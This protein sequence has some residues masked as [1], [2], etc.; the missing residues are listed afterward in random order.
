MQKLRRSRNED[1][2]LTG[3]PLR[4]QP[5]NLCQINSGGN[6]G[7]WKECEGISLP[8]VACLS[9]L[10]GRPW[11]P[12][13]GTKR[14]CGF[15]GAWGLSSGLA[16]GEGGGTITA[17]L[18]RQDPKPLWVTL[19]G[20][21]ERWLILSESEVAARGWAGDWQLKLWAHRDKQ[22]RGPRMSMALAKC[23]GQTP[24]SRMPWNLLVGGRAQAWTRSLMVQW[25]MKAVNWNKSVCKEP[26]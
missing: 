22:T 26:D 1:S 20:L 19:L 18:Q 8:E 23:C 14:C 3:W 11:D 5:E 21:W 25:W 4:C 17:S 10:N 7:F 16:G 9:C 12:E 2:L 6:N 13:A 15:N 24:S